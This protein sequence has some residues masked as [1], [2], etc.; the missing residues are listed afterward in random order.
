MMEEMW[1]QSQT[2][3]EGATQAMAIEAFPFVMSSLSL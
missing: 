2:Q 1:T 3:S